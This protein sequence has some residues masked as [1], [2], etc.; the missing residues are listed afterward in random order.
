MSIKDE[1]RKEAESLIEQAKEGIEERAD[2]LL[3]QA[4]TEN[5]R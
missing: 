2:D 5:R 4:K 1:I 3:G